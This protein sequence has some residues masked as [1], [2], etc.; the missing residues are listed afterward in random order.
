MGELLVTTVTSTALLEA[1][2]NPANQGVW[3][4][5]ESRYRPVVF[6]VARRLGLTEVDAA[7][8]AQEALLEFFRDYRAGKYDPGR[9][10]LRSWFLAIA[11]NRARDLVRRSARGSHDRGESVV[12]GLEDPNVELERVWDAE[13]ENEILRRAFEALRKEHDTDERSIAIFEAYAIQGESPEAIAETHGVSPS[14]VYSIKSRCTARL[15]DWVEAGRR[16]YDLE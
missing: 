16:L 4:E 2:A 8:V 14:T 11:R 6:H 10:R 7:D 3:E 15:R 13:V 1:L 9:G 5:L 12:A